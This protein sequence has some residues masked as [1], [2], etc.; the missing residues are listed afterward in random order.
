[1]SILTDVTVP[2]RSKPQSSDAKLND[3]LRKAREDMESSGPRPRVGA[4]VAHE[5]YGIMRVDQASQH[6]LICRTIYTEDGPTDGHEHG[7]VPLH[8]DDVDVLL[9]NGNWPMANMHRTIGVEHR[10]NRIT[11]HRL[12]DVALSHSGVWLQVREAWDSIN[13]DKR[14]GK[15]HSVRAEELTWL[16]TFGHVVLAERVFPPVT[17]PADLA[18]EPADEWVDED[19][20]DLSTPAGRADEASAILE[21]FGE[22]QRRLQRID[23]DDARAATGCRDIADHVESLAL[24]TRKAAMDAELAERFPDRVAEPAETETDTTESEAA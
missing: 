18:E 3:D 22:L 20:H 12:Y 9:V 6:A 10:G 16:D 15:L 1:M 23:H 14:D 17:L 7:S 11:V 8:T 24:S 2:P 13:G 21:L 5:D 19:P 4:I